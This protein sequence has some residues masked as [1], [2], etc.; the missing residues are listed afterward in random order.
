M[1]KVNI[2]LYAQTH[3]TKNQ[4]LSLLSVRSKIAHDF[5]ILGFV[6]KC[7]KT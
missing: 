2:M 7:I 6:F 3:T 5:L 1:Q 4:K